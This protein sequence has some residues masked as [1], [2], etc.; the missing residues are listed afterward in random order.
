[1]TLI[2]SNDDVAKLLSMRECIDV[3]ED[4]YVELSTGRGVNRVRS[5]CLVPTG[6]GDALYSLKSMFVTPNRPS[7]TPF[8]GWRNSSCPV[9]Q[10]RMV[11]ASTAVP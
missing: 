11:M 2:L 3:L 10:L 1:M 7:F 9:V 4:V 6:Q 5:D 8:S